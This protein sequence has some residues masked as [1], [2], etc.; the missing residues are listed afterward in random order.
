MNRLF[1]SLAF[2]WQGL[3]NAWLTQRNFR[4]EIGIALA[5]TILAIYLRTGLLPI[6]I[7]VM[8]VLASELINSSIE[9]LVDLTTQGVHPLAKAAKDYAAASVLITSFGSLAIGILV[10]GP[11]LLER[12]LSWL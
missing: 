9:A 5:A 8:L 11:A 10:L 6:L 4:I 12:I 7:C 1:R 3:S 2:A